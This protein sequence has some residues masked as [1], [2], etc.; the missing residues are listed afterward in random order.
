MEEECNVAV[1]EVDRQK[2]LYQKCQLKVGLVE[3]VERGLGVAEQKAE[4]VAQVVGVQVLGK[5]V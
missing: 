4:Q 2:V 5:V 1:Q 3:L